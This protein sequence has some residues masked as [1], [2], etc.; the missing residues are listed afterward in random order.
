MLLCPSTPAIVRVDVPDGKLPL[1]L[2][3]ANQSVWAHMLTD[4]H[5]DGDTPW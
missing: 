5:R 3:D 1:K 4:A 2:K